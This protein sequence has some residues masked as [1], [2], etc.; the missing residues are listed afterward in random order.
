MIDSRLLE[1]KVLDELGG[2][3]RGLFLYSQD[4]Q[5][6]A[7]LVEISVKFS[8]ERRKGKAEYFADFLYCDRQ[9]VSV[10]SHNLDLLRKKVEKMTQR[11]LTKGF[12][13]LNG[14]YTLV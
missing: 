8:I 7:R 14:G 2:K 6:Y 13:P 11:L 1:A 5:M 10:T 3:R 4:E 12:E 9:V